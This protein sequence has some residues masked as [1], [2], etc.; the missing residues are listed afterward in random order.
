MLIGINILP[1]IK[2]V[3]RFTEKAKQYYIQWIEKYKLKIGKILN[4]T[5]NY[6]SSLITRFY[7]DYKSKKGINKYILLLKKIW[8][9]KDILIIEGEHT[10]FGVGNN[11]I[12]SFISN[13]FI[14][15]EEKR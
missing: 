2:D 12:K 7:I 6:Y 3:H 15:N 1:N 11:L 13:L 14:I 10:K 8:D 5:K 9:K 4:K